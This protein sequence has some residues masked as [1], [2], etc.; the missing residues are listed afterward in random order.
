MFWRFLGVFL[1]V[2]FNRVECELKIEMPPPPFY[3]SIEINST[4]K[5]SECSIMSL[6]DVPPAGAPP[7]PE[8]DVQVFLT[9]E[10]DPDAADSTSGLFNTKSG[11]P[12]FIRR[13]GQDVI[14]DNATRTKYVVNVLKT[15]PRTELIE[16][17]FETFAKKQ[18]FD[19]FHVYHC[20]SSKLTDAVLETLCKTGMKLKY[21][22]VKYDK[23]PKEKLIV[24]LI[25]AVAPKTLVLHSEKK[26]KISDAFFKNPAVRSVDSLTLPFIETSISDDTL[27]GLN[28]SSASIG[29][30]SRITPAGIRR[31]M[32]PCL[33]LDVNDKKLTAVLS[34][35]VDEKVLDGLDYKKENVSEGDSWTIT[36]GKEAFKFRV[37]EI[38]SQKETMSYLEIVHVKEEPKKHAVGSMTPNALTATAA[39]SSMSLG[40]LLFAIF[41]ILLN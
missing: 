3:L 10:L 8:I 20:R 26:M 1:I 14:F 2:Y 13:L 17:L 4:R 7:K 23:P 33:N 15:I 37:S 41:C 34:F 19:A 12:I 22:E 6:Q 31:W 5:A 28:M 40:T 25:K 24:R 38:L 27:A 29:K 36:N 32:Q 18:T 35:I 30:A 16:F 21:C 11:R 39:S 9:D